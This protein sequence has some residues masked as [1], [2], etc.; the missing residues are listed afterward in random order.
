MLDNKIPPPSQKPPGK[1]DLTAPP[2]YQDIFQKPASPKDPKE[3]FAIAGKKLNWFDKLFHRRKTPPPAPSP[4]P[5]ENPFLEL[6]YDSRG[7]K[8]KKIKRMQEVLKKWAPPALKDKIRTN[9][10]YGKETAMVVELFKLIYGFGN[11]GNKMDAN[12]AGALL[13][14]ENGSFWQKDENNNPVYPKTPEGN[15]WYKCAEKRGFPLIDKNTPLIGDEISFIARHLPEKII[16]YDGYTLQAQTAKKF[17][18]FKNFVK[19]KF[20]EYNFLITCTM[21]YMH[22]SSSHADGKA[23]DF[24]VLDEKGY[25]ITNA[26]SIRIESMANQCGFKTFNEYVNWSPYK[27]GNHMHVEIE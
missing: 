4:E 25:S 17:I 9:G 22:I 21:G 12:T 2:S 24:I 27:T 1:I 3:L 13:N 19:T 7:Y 11:D 8:S 23:I 6:R 5:S 20:P 14:I 10:T 16:N 26:E 15:F 18:G